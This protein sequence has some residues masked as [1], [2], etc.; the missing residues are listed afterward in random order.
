VTT[1]GLKIYSEYKTILMNSPKPG[2]SSVASVQ[3]KINGHRAVRPNYLVHC[4]N[5]YAAIIT[6]PPRPE[7]ETIL[8]QPC[9]MCN[10][11]EQSFCC[12]YCLQKNIIYWD[13]KHFDWLKNNREIKQWNHAIT[14]LLH[15]YFL[16]LTCWLVS[17]FP[18]FWITDS[19]SSFYL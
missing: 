6:I 11:L 1:T 12:D 4:F 9:P 5:C 16:S 3:E 17:Q 18:Q 8:T 2:G 7:Y 15:S 19:N 13:K 10:G 14:E